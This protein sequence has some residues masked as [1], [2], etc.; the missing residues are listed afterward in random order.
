MCSHSSWQTLFCQSLLETLVAAFVSMEPYLV[1]TE[2]STPHKSCNAF[3]N[4]L[5]FLPGT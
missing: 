5:S 2:K 1:A 3:L 4:T